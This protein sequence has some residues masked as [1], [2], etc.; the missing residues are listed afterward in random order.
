MMQFAEF[1]PGSQVSVIDARGRELRKRALSSV[2]PGRDFLI[3]W[4]CREEEWQAAESEGRRPEG[5]P[6]PAED[7]R[8]A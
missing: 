7:V 1:S 5:V 3:V 8:L 2:V 6:W 4:V